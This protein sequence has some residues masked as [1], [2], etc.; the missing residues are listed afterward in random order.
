VVLYRTSAVRLHGTVLNLL[1]V[2]IIL[3]RI[4]LWSSGQKFLATD[5]EARVRFPALP[6]KKS[7]GSGTGSTQPSEYN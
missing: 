2:G 1:S 4:S 7:S 6:E 5:L 3:F